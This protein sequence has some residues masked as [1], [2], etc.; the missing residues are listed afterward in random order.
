MSGGANRCTCTAG[1]ADI[2]LDMKR[3]VH[4]HIHTPA[5]Q[6][7]GTVAHALAHAHTQSTQDAVVIFGGKA[8]LFNTVLLRKIFEHGDIR[9]FGEQQFHNQLAS[10]M[11]RFGVGFDFHAFPDGI[12][13]CRYKSASAAI[14]EFHRAEAAHAGRFECFVM[15]E[16]GDID[17]VLFSN[18]K[19]V[20]PL[21]TLNCF[22]VELKRDHKS[23]P[24]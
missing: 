24:Y 2:G 11:D 17:T 9:T 7:D 20:L 8:R 23:I 22:A 10:L 15:A 14:K 21:V 1:H 13:A 6:A 18:L 3:R 16:G 12:I 5:G 19:D 4:L